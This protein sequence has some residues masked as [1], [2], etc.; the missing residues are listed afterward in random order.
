MQ[1]GYEHL[2]VLQ[3]LTPLTRESKLIEGLLA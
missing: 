3:H 1:L 2:G